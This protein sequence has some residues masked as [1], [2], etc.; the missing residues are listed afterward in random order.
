MSDALYERYKD[1]LRRGHVAAVRDRLDAALVA[2]SEA[3][4][5]AP[6]RPLPHASLAGI[7]VKLGRNEEALAAFGRAIDRAP[8]DEAALSGRAELL[9]TLGRRVDAADDLDAVANSQEAS[10]RLVDAADTALR[11]LQLAESKTRRRHIEA[12]ARTLRETPG[13]DLAAS[14]L[15]QALG[16]TE[17]TSVMPDASAGID[18]AVE[19]QPPADG[20]QLTAEAEDLLDADDTDG[21]RVR[22]IDA[23]RAHYANGRLNAALDACYMALGIAPFDFEVHLLL[24]EL[25]LEQGWRSPAADKLVLLGRVVDLADDVEGRRRICALAS[26]RIPDD[27]RLVA[28]CA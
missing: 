25:Y 14:A 28:L 3:A 10:G 20:A 4:E 8:Q 24:A 9:A 12:L 18:E 23:A 7:L 22:L 21:A 15:E 17:A 27:E 11:A 13:Q 19:S 26:A 5:I 2:Y 6:E 16:G 1:A